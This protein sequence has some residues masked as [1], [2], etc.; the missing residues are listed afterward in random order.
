[1]KK[2]KKSAIWII[3]IASTVVVA[4]ATVLTIV[5]ANNRGARPD[6]SN[7]RLTTD[8]SLLVS[9]IN[10][11]LNSSV[12]NNKNQAVIV[13]KD[14]FEVNS[15]AGYFDDNVI[16]SPGVDGYHV[17][18]YPER[19]N[20]DVSVMLID[21]AIYG[22]NPFIFNHEEIK[23]ALAF[24]NHFVIYVTYA[25][26]RAEY[27]VC[28]AVDHDILVHKRYEVTMNDNKA[29]QNGHLFNVMASDNFFTVLLYSNDSYYYAF[30]EYL[31]DYTYADNFTYA[32]EEE[33]VYNYAVMGNDFLYNNAS[34]VIV[35]TYDEELGFI[36]K[37][38]DGVTTVFT[39]PNGTIIQKATVHNSKVLGAQL[40]GG[41]YLT[42]SYTLQAN[43][44][45]LNI[46][47]GEYNKIS[48][49]MYASK[50]YF[51]LFLQKV[52]SNGSLVDGGLAVYYDYNLKPIARYSASSQASRIYY[53]DNAR[54]LTNDGVYTTKNKVELAQIYSFDS[55]GM[56]FYSAIA[57]GKFVLKSAADSL[58]IYNL[59]MKQVCVNSFDEIVNF[60]DDD[61]IIFK[62]QGEFYRY[63]LS[64]NVVDDLNYIDSQF[65]SNSSLHL[66]EDGDVYYLYDGL[67]KK[68][69]V[70]TSYHFES[71]KLLYFTTADAE[72]V[73]YL[74]DEDGAYTPSS[75]GFSSLSD[76][77]EDIYSADPDPADPVWYNNGVATGD[78]SVY[79]EP[80]WYD[81]DDLILTTAQNTNTSTATEYTI[82]ASHC[83]K[84]GYYSKVNYYDYFEIHYNGENSGGMTTYQPWRLY[85]RVEIIGGQPQVK[86]ISYGHHLVERHLLDGSDT[87]T[88]IKN[89]LEVRAKPGYTNNPSTSLSYDY[90]NSGFPIYYY[91]ASAMGGTGII[92]ITTAADDI[93]CKAEVY[94]ESIKVTLAFDFKCNSSA[95]LKLKLNESDGTHFGKT[96]YNSADVWED[97]N[98]DIKTVVSSWGISEADYYNKLYYQ[99][100]VLGLKTSGGEGLPFNGSFNY[101]QK[102]V[103]TTADAAV[104]QYFIDN[105]IPTFFQG[106]DANK[107][108][109]TTSV[110]SSATSLTDYVATVS[111]KINYNSSYTKLH[112]G[113]IALDISGGRLVGL[114]GLES[115]SPIAQSTLYNFASKTYRNESLLYKAYG[116]G[117]PL[118]YD[119][120]DYQFLQY[121]E[122]NKSY[123]FNIKN[124]D[125]I[126]TEGALN[127]N[128]YVYCLYEP[129]TYYFELDYNV[130]AEDNE[131]A[132]LAQ[133][134]AYLQKYAGL[135]IGIEGQVDYTQFAKNWAYTNVTEES[136]GDSP[137]EN[138]TAD[139]QK[140]E[141]YDFTD[142]S[143]RQEAKIERKL[144]IKR[145]DNVYEPYMARYLD[146]YYVEILINGVLVPF[147]F[148]KVTAGYISGGYKNE[149]EC[150]RVDNKIYL[151]ASRNTSSLNDNCAAVT[152][153]GTGAGYSSFYAQEKIALPTKSEYD[154]YSGFINSDNRVLLCIDFSKNSTV[155]EA[156]YIE[157]N[158]CAGDTAE[159]WATIKS[160][161]NDNSRYHYITINGDRYFL[162]KNISTYI[163]SY[164]GLSGSHLYLMAYRD[165]DELDDLYSYEYGYMTQIDVSDYATKAYI[166]NCSSFAIH[167]DLSSL[168]NMT[169]AYYFT[170]NM[171]TRTA[172]YDDINKNVTEKFSFK[173]TDSVMFTS[174]PQHLH[175]TF[176]GWK[177]I[178]GDM[179]EYN[180]GT[181]IVLPIWLMLNPNFDINP[182][183]ATNYYLAST[184][185]KYGEVWADYLT[186]VNPDGTIN[187]KTTSVIENNPI[188]LI[189]QWKPVTCTVEVTLWTKQTGEDYKGCGP[190]TNASGE[191]IGISD[192]FVVSPNGTTPRFT[193]GGVDIDKDYL[194]MYDGKLNASITFK[195]SRHNTFQS[196]A[197]A[198]DEAGFLTAMINSTGMECKIIGWVYRHVGAT[199]TETEYRNILSTPSETFGE[200]VGDTTVLKIFALYAPSNYNVY[201][202]LYP[203]GGALHDNSS[204]NYHGNNDKIYNKEISE[205]RYN[206][207]VKSSWVSSFLQ[208]YINADSLHP[209]DNLPGMTDPTAVINH[210]SMTEDQTSYQID[211]GGVFTVRSNLTF[212][213]QDAYQAY[214][215][216]K[217][218]FKNVTLYNDSGQYEKYTL[219]F[220]YNHYSTSNAGWSV[221]VYSETNPGGTLS[222]NPSNAGGLITFTFGNHVNN[223]QYNVFSIENSIYGYI[224]VNINNISNPGSLDSGKLT[225]EEGFSLDV[226]LESFAS[227][228][229]SVN[230]E[231]EEDSENYWLFNYNSSLLTAG[232]PLTD[233]EGKSLSDGEKA[234]AWIG[235]SQYYF[236]RWSDSVQFNSGYYLI[237]VGDQIEA[238]FKD[239]YTYEQF[240]GQGIYRDAD[241]VVY[242]DS[243][244]NMLFYP[245]QRGLNGQ[246]SQTSSPLRIEPISSTVSNYYIL[247]NNVEYYIYSG[248]SVEFD[249]NCKDGANFKDIYLIASVTP[250]T[251]LNMS[252]TDS[253]YGVTSSNQNYYTPGKTDLVVHLLPDGT[254]KYY[255]EGVTTLYP[256]YNNT[257]VI[258]IDPEQKNVYISNAPDYKYKEGGRFELQYYIKNLK[259]DGYEIAFARP[260]RQIVNGGTYYTYSN[261]ILHEDGSIVSDTDYGNN[262]FIMYCGV[263]YTIQDG[264]EITLP[265]DSDR[266]GADVYYFYLTRD[267]NGFTRYFLMYDIP[268]N[269][270]KTRA[271]AT[272]NLVEI[273]VT[274]AKLLHELEIIVVEED[275]YK[276]SWGSYNELGVDYYYQIIDKSFE[277]KYD[278]PY[279]N[280]SS[281][282]SYSFEDI[283]PDSYRYS[284]QNIKNFPNDA[285]G[286]RILKGYTFYQYA[287]DSNGMIISDEV[288]IDTADRDQW[289]QQVS[290]WDTNYIEKLENLGDVP[291]LTWGSI[292][293]FSPCDTNILK[294]NATDGY[295]IK[296]I[297]ISFGMSESVAASK[298]E[299]DFKKII[300][301]ELDESSFDDLVYVSST[302]QYSY[303][304]GAASL[305][306]LK[307]KIATDVDT[308]VHGTSE[309]IGFDILAGL[310]HTGNSGILFSN[311]KEH[312]WVS[313]DAY[314]GVSDGTYTLDQIFVLLSG[315]YGDVKIDLHT[316][317][318]SEYLIESGA[319]SGDQNPLLKID[320]AFLSAN[321]DKDYATFTQG[322]VLD[323]NGQDAG[324]V[325]PLMCYTYLNLYTQKWN[326]SEWKWEFDLKSEGIDLTSGS[327]P[328]DFGFST[329]VMHDRTPMKD[330]NSVDPSTGASSTIEGQNYIGDK[331]MAL[332][333]LTESDYG[334]KE[335]TIR[336]IFCGTVSR[337]RGGLHFMASHKDYSVYLTNG[338]YYNQPSS[339]FVST[340]DAFYNLD[341]Y[342]GRTVTDKAIAKDSSYDNVSGNFITE[343]TY[344]GLSQATSKYDVYFEVD[345]YKYYLFKDGLGTQI[346]DFNTRLLSEN[347]AYIRF[348]RDAPYAYTFHGNPD[349]DRLTEADFNA[350]VYGGRY[351]IVRCELGPTYISYTYHTESGLSGGLNYTNKL[352]YLSTGPLDDKYLY[353]GYNN[354]SR[355]PNDGGYYGYFAPDRADFVGTYE[356]NYKFFVSMNA[357]LNTITVQ[358]DSY[359][360]DKEV[361]AGTYPA[362]TTPSS[363]TFANDNSNSY[364]FFSDGKLAL[365]GNQIY[366]RD[367][368]NKRDSWFNDT[369]LTNMQLFSY[370]DEYY[371]NSVLN[372]QTWVNR[373]EGNPN[374]SQIATQEMKGYDFKWTYYSIAGYKL[375][376]ILIYLPDVK[377]YYYIHVD[378]VVKK[379]TQAETDAGKTTKN[380]FI[381]I[382]SEHTSYASPG[383][384]FNYNFRLEF[385]NNL[386]DGSYVVQG[387]SYTLYPIIYL[388][389]EPNGGMNNE[390]GT[391]LDS[392][393]N[394]YVD[395][396]NSINLMANNIKVAFISTP[397]SYQINYKNYDLTDGTHGVSTTSSMQ[398]HGND[399]QSVIYDSMTR[400]NTY[401][402]MTGYTFVGWGSEE[403]YDH[404]SNSYISRYEIQTSSD[405]SSTWNSRS[406]WYDP[407]Q[408][409]VKAGNVKTAYSSV[410]D[411]H[412][413]FYSFD[414]N[415]CRAFYVKNGYFVTDTGYNSGA[416]QENYNFFGNYAL[417][418]S[419]NIINEWQTRNEDSE[420]LEIDLYAIFK[421]NVYTIQFD[422]NNVHGDAY[423]MNFLEQTTSGYTVSDWFNTKFTE[424]NLGIY[425]YPTNNVNQKRTY[426][427][428]IAFDTNNWFYSENL[429]QE[430]VYAY[431][432]TNVGNYPYNGT[433][434]D[435]DG[436]SDPYISYDMAKD[437]ADLSRLSIDMFGY[438]W[439]G[440]FYIKNS[441]ENEGIDL[442]QGFIQDT[443]VFSSSYYNSPQGL[444]KLDANFYN[445]LGGSIYNGADSIHEVTNVQDFVY[446]GQHKANEKIAFSLKDPSAAIDN[447][448]F[449]ILS[450]TL[451]QIKFSDRFY[452]FKIDTT[453]SMMNK[454]FELYEDDVCTQKVK[455]MYVEIS[456]EIFDAGVYKPKTLNYY[457]TTVSA[458][459]G[460]V[461]FYDYSPNGVGVY[462]QYIHFGGA[463]IVY[464]SVEDSL[465]VFHWESNANRFIYSIKSPN[466][467]VFSYFDTSLGRDAYTVSGSSGNYYVKINRTNP[468]YVRHITLY[469]NWVNNQYTVR[470]DPLDANGFDR[471]GSSFMREYA[472]YQTSYQTYFNDI[473]LKTEFLWR[474]NYRQYVQLPYRVGYDFVGWSFNYINPNGY[475]KQYADII[476]QPSQYLYLCKELFAGYAVLNN[477]EMDISG[478]PTQ[479][480]N[481]YESNILM[482]NGTRINGAVTDDWILNQTG[483]GEHLG[484]DEGN[485]STHSTRFVYVFPVWRAQTFSINISLNINRE[486]LQNLY[487]KDSSF[488]IGLYNSADHTSYTGVTSNYYTLDQSASWK[489]LG[490][491]F[492]QNY[493]KDIV[494]NI[495]FEIEFDQ[496]FDTAKLTFAGRTYTLKDLCITSAGYY[497]LGLLYDATGA[498]KLDDVGVAEYNEYLDGQSQRYLLRNTLMSVL[499]RETSGTIVQHDNAGGEV[500]YRAGAQDAPTITYVPDGD[501]NVSVLDYYWYMKLY[502]SKFVANSSEATTPVLINGT[503]GDYEN[504]GGC[505]TNFG[506]VTGGGYSSIPIKSEQ[507][508]NQYYLYIHLSKADKHLVH[509]YYVVFYYEPV[510]PIL[511]DISFDRTFLYFNERDTNGNFLN[512]YIIYNDGTR[513]YFVNDRGEFVYITVQTA[514]YK[515]MTNSYN[516]ANKLTSLLDGESYSG[517]VMPTREITLYAHWMERDITSTVANGNNSGNK[518]DSNPGLAGYYKIDAQSGNKES[519]ADNADISLTYNFYENVAYTFLPFYNGRYLSELTLE[520]D[521]LNEV[522]TGSV[523]EFTMIKNTLIIRFTFTNADDAENH[524]LKATEMYWNGVN[525]TSAMR[526]SSAGV[527]GTHLFETGVVNQANVSNIPAL[528]LIDKYGMTYSDGDYKSSVRQYKYGSYHGRNDVNQVTLDLFNMMTSVNF[529]CKFSLQTFQVEVYN[530]IVNESNKPK[531]NGQNYTSNLSSET[532]MLDHSNYRAEN[533]ASYGAPYVSNMAFANTFGSTT[534][535]NSALQVK[536]YN[537][538]YYYNMG[539]VKASSAD[540]FSGLN[541][542]YDKAYY[543]NGVTTET[544]GASGLL[545]KLQ[546]NISS[547]YSGFDGVPLWYHYIS[548]GTTNINLKSLDL[549]AGDGYVK[550]NRVVY[551]FFKSGAESSTAVKFYYWDN[552]ADNNQGKYV[553]YKNNEYEYTSGHS[554]SLINGNKITK[555]PS[556]SIASWYGGAD[557]SE[558]NKKF[559]GYVCIDRSVYD[560]MVDVTAIN[561]EYGSSKM[562]SKTAYLDTKA[563]ILSYLYNKKEITEGNTVTNI[564]IVGNN[565]ALGLLA[566]RITVLGNKSYYVKSEGGIDYLDAV[567]VEITLDFVVTVDGVE[568]TYTD[569]VIEKDL[570]M[571]NV[572]K[573]LIGGEDT[574]A[575]PLY[576]DIEFS[577]IGY[578][579]DILNDILGE[580]LVSLS[581]NSNHIRSNVFEVNSNYTIFYNP[582][583]AR[584]AISN[585]TN[586]S[587]DAIDSYVHGGDAYLT[588]E[589]NTSGVYYNFLSQD[590]TYSS[591][592]DEGGSSSATAYS[593]GLRKFKTSA[594]TYYLHLYYVDKAGKAFIKSSNYIRLT[595][596]GGG[597]SG[598][599]NTN[600]E[601]MSPLEGALNS[602]NKAYYQSALKE[603]RSFEGMLP[604]AEIYNRSLAVYV[605]LQLHQL[606]NSGDLLIYNNV[607]DYNY[608]TLYGYDANSGTDSTTEQV[609]IKRIIEALNARIN[610]QTSVSARLTNMVGLY[611]MAYSIAYY[612]VKTTQINGG[613]T[614]GLER[615]Y[616]D[617]SKNNFNADAIS[618]TM[619]STTFTS[620]SVLPGDFF[621]DDRTYVDDVSGDGPILVKDVIT[622]ERAYSYRTVYSGTTSANAR[623][624]MYLYAVDETIY[625]IT[626]KLNAD[627]KFVYKTSTPVP[628]GESGVVLEI[629]ST[630]LF[631]RVYQE[632]DKYQTFTFDDPFDRP[633]H[634]DGGTTDDVNDFVPGWYN[635]MQS[636]DFYR[637]EVLLNGYT[638]RKGTKGHCIIYYHITSS[639]DS[640]HI[641]GYNKTIYV[642]AAFCDSNNYYLKGDYEA[643]VEAGY[644]AYE[645]AAEAWA[646]QE[647]PK[648]LDDYADDN[649]EGYA[650]ERAGNVFDIHNKIEDYESS[651]Q[652]ETARNEFIDLNYSSYKSGGWSD[653]RA[654][655]EYNIS[656]YT[657]ENLKRDFI[658]QV[659]DY[660]K[661]EI[662]KLTAYE[663][664][665]ESSK[666]T[667]NNIDFYYYNLDECKVYYCITNSS[668]GSVIGK[669]GAYDVPDNLF[670]NTG[671]YRVDSGTSANSGAGYDAGCYWLRIAPSG[672]V[673]VE[674][675]HIYTRYKSFFYR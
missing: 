281:F 576:E 417:A 649:W 390:T 336:I 3:S 476:N 171:H 505:S 373:S 329:G 294:I 146:M 31:S 224:D 668:A 513:T 427:A 15:N 411:Y 436:K 549:N 241:M 451:G 637:L 644:Q 556:A 386:N 150:P 270:Q 525:V 629:K 565:T 562:K 462:V 151:Y 675:Q 215:V 140:Y 118:D 563:D 426:Y 636:M 460:Y 42:Y 639:G 437:G 604:D 443:Q 269:D 306:T 463:D 107:E 75:G 160:F 446:K 105:Q 403:Y 559:L 245:T 13:E 431:K 173:Y 46:D 587:L 428:Y 209:Y 85:Y 196:I 260:T 159:T 510:A 501:Y 63:N 452:Y 372:P 243:D 621:K 352:V 326:D 248:S 653:A 391:F 506:F 278:F 128:R 509:K 434:A 586:L 674:S 524:T 550:T 566:N 313:S 545:N 333:Y 89:N 435:T 133:E 402:T 153:P 654:Y 338:K 252:L 57:R 272:N 264:I 17:Y 265:A 401:I 157:R 634:A 455:N 101:T 485:Y 616:G 571:L 255:T 492:Y 575:V 448:Q 515:T 234:F 355:E 350:N 547:K 8:Q 275:L 661:P 26:D 20:K 619:I 35:A 180:A 330:V 305:P 511:G 432:V 103:S 327:S 210:L 367:D 322:V 507:V 61:N 523:A 595:S 176:D 237:H 503:L 430:L 459:D 344:S 606:I 496:P 624:A 440:W 115:I 64:S 519:A 247:I 138:G 183:S 227:K 512:R 92:P 130:Q 453:Q 54:I 531:P 568:K 493:Y 155:G 657:V 213:I 370:K 337:I 546:A 650:R 154:N 538:P 34:M 38:N 187:W 27:I 640:Y 43:G 165:K 539:S 191:V 5:I 82:M 273:N 246:I 290:I 585:S 307:Y 74:I 438:S 267:P 68:D 470:F 172:V 364:N 468:A 136:I 239:Q 393:D 472:L 473:K 580:G 262:S 655:A 615:L 494:A 145:S 567:R 178:A 502:N 212:R 216:K 384:N 561:Y 665:V 203:H 277:V 647:R 612:H 518:Y 383:S 374:V 30:Y 238:E 184:G 116:S 192:D 399:T 48:A 560:S 405:V 286:D 22:A 658:G 359:L 179:T 69:Y 33:H 375:E 251:S 646:K 274:F 240:A 422:V 147:Y 608:S 271:P 423:Y 376:Y 219:L 250:V 385:N 356:S 669:T 479:I 596:T 314:D 491:T 258:A 611:R 37:P 293:R 166:P 66:V 666:R 21:H 456:D 638:T 480:T 163:K 671:R 217:L 76:S 231:F 394:A 447:L 445:L 396:L 309:S 53:A 362:G 40:V 282:F 193:I 339:S 201:L 9:E 58:F 398:L 148:N 4:L 168:T 122:A 292:T 490:Y 71:D 197:V 358:T 487:E 51:G 642:H 662:S 14:D 167:I 593:F 99:T 7:Y 627:G 12:A 410:L 90:L 442:T 543:L 591:S 354:L 134:L 236:G 95:Y 366:Q 41:K 478:V 444:P 47:L 139:G 220:T 324:M 143:T 670:P 381:S 287:T 530:V 45:T 170:T 126:Y 498:D 318:F 457:R 387:T 343:T 149:S 554:T 600:A 577:I 104:T 552:T 656:A 614:I 114:T 144:S 464:Y 23:V 408:Y 667:F 106:G 603:L 276:E 129:M 590:R 558:K 564:Q 412:F 125:A 508:G 340:N 360:F 377:M 109:I 504:I 16:W 643:A 81:Y 50:N 416:Q 609:N 161:E 189:A 345:G 526:I 228:N 257:R 206:V 317:S 169:R 659:S 77:K 97:P 392:Y 49:K 254:V 244:T 458:V 102:L 500:S 321:T 73:C 156:W 207:M 300:Q 613:D 542:I 651:K 379:M 420:V 489:G 120:V 535:I 112:I 233:K 59:N 536:S 652:F 117:N 141:P 574:Y 113:T 602:T 389:E 279:I 121:D 597:G 88:C 164:T 181:G 400:L 555:L 319:E 363:N 29:Y 325:S 127:T 404:V 84:N 253:D 242:Y 388:G 579:N 11:T 633:T 94:G 211:L 235:A 208:Y 521:T 331:Y 548:D 361:L 632:M 419:A 409:F 310:V 335:D 475:Y 541:H 660:V 200:Y 205:A 522:K 80:E 261:F 263:E 303:T 605:L 186:S 334:I 599:A 6:N 199:P 557:S 349:Y 204:K 341:D 10:K 174:N 365:N 469:A 537:V 131:N 584:I 108:I 474:D 249:V 406:Q 348:Y 368:T 175:Y 441:L 622:G 544:L 594:N 312:D 573:E 382:N 24:R 124:V 672:S 454:Y 301:F 289:L 407:T 529:T 194:G 198:I 532:D 351:L 311:M 65:S 461:Y 308:A 177:F 342:A 93:K 645:D 347:I 415:P 482:V 477:I 369:V 123:Y 581:S 2:L 610:R 222:V 553:Q 221:E 346:T 288:P 100:I 214:Y 439:L 499:K 25:D 202:N 583:N 256:G 481:P 297:A 433:G 673:S 52:D 142:N 397:Y 323:E 592:I 601:P 648:V 497:F 483:F 467:M 83:I 450:S 78:A 266:I 315:L 517:R 18:I 527:G 79:V 28:S 232:Q 635:L 486:Q 617:A 534:S 226:I 572:A 316:T 291:T 357:V 296:S 295:I 378:S 135:N 484:D 229:E 268:E 353:D 418:F 111:N 551:G 190:E 429:G 70:I 91:A 332:Y 421:A 137:L 618:D 218:L 152:T 488:A 623:I 414:N 259:I 86:I 620:H 283:V 533:V 607:V 641:E 87:S 449:D 631:D 96:A 589:L 67:V 36:E 223:T 182:I 626:P 162:Q 62:S 380:G 588:I 628:D 110:N 328:T 225:G 32:V 540:S 598:T 625:L 466:N 119:I 285:N 185:T 302:G 39:L 72:Y 413:Y 44:K 1:M 371:L 663:Y 195:Y 425:T 395:K 495:C 528:S 582:E 98:T 630:N 471:I 514:I 570:K 56:E 320:E 55:I 280:N 569:V 465:N 188:K 516:S 298:G 19:D 60:I 132:G 578:E 424:N 158:V 664:K 230:I 284:Y 520:F 299:E 304:T